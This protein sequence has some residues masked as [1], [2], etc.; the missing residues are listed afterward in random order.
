MAVVV[1]VVVGLDMITITKVFAKAL[2]KIQAIDQALA[3]LY[4]T[5]MAICSLA[6][7]MLVI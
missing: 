5:L 7:Q 2:M 4:P 1:V 6:V 3:L